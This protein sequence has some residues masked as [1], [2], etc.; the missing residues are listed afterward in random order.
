MIGSVLIARH[1]GPS[2]Q[3]ELV[4]LLLIPQM[5]INFGDLGISESYMY[6]LSKNNDSFV[7]LKSTIIKTAVLILTLMLS[8]FSVYLVFFSYSENYAIIFLAYSYIILLFVSQILSFILRGYYKLREFNF[9]LLILNSAILISVIICITMDFSIKYLFLFYAISHCI[10]ILYILI[11]LISVKNNDLSNK[12]IYTIKDVFLYGIKIYSYKVLNSA[13]S[14]FD[15]FIIA[16]FLVSSQ[17][18]FYSVAVV[19]SSVL[20]L[21]LV[22]PI[23]LI[24][25]PILNKI[26]DLKEKQKLVTLI[27]KVIFWIGIL[28]GIFLF[29]FSEIIILNIYGVEYLPAL[30]PLWILL[31]GVILKSPMSI[32]AYYFKS[33]GTPEVMVR[34]SIITVILNISAGIFF[35]PS[36]GITAA[37]IISTITYTIY[38][39]LLS[40]KYLKTTNNGYLSQYLFNKTEINLIIIYLQKFTFKKQ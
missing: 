18:G 37:A 32:L 9:G 7:L 39:I 29:L 25:L 12:K 11:N 3:G 5:I 15:K 36:F 23:A 21:F 20:Y 28:F 17:L 2:V 30:V 33:I 19:L 22:K 6:H 31:F 8:I 16:S 38:S 34:I 24:L 10:S 14:Q 26:E 13:E 27:N 40:S 4:G 35:I 1:Y